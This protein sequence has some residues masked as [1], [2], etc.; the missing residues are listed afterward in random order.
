MTISMWR[1]T[2]LTDD[3]F[4]SLIR[5]DPQAYAK[6]LRTTFCV[7]YEPNYDGVDQMEMWLVENCT[8]LVFLDEQHHGDQDGFFIY[9]EHDADATKF[10]L[11]WEGR[12]FE[13][14]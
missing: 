5:A 3:E 14:E 4:K 11:A 13:D 9:F 10:K 1:T 12:E 8:G 7:N 6:M 2:V